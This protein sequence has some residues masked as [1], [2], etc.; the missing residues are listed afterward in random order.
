MCKCSQKRKRKTQV[1]FQKEG[2]FH[3][4]E[5]KKIDFITKPLL[6]I[7]CFSSNT[8]HFVCRIVIFFFSSWQKVIKK[9]NVP[10]SIAPIGIFLFFSFYFPVPLFML[11]FFFSSSSL[12]LCVCVCVCVCDSPLVLFLITTILQW[13]PC[14]ALHFSHR[15]IY[16]W[17]FS[18]PRH[19]NSPSSP[20]SHLNF[21][22]S[23]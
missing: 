15:P 17:M 8:L 7:C 16:W 10:L 5:N 21:L 22:S 20:S 18:C 23:F 11:L 3:F 19:P 13:L 4:S 1:P 9:N 12:S 2:T 14:Q 6:I